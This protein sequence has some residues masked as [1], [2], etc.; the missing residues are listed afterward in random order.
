MHTLST[1]PSRADSNVGWRSLNKCIIWLQRHNEAGAL[2]GGL[3]DGQDEST[4]D[5]IYEKSKTVLDFT[6]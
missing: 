3:S 6:S 1:I 4:Q 5:T 2:I